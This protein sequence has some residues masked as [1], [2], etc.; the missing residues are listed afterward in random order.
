MRTRDQEW[1]RT[2]VRGLRAQMI[3]QTNV[4]LSWAFAGD[5]ELIRIPR[6]KVHEGEFG[7]ILNQSWARD[8]AMLWWSKAL[9]GA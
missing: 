1:R 7:A 5:R 2:Q 8:Y 3:E 9:G 4:F 6:R